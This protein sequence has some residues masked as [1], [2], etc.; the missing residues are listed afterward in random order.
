V[1]ESQ[2]EQWVPPSV[3]HNVDRSRD[4]G[5]RRIRGIR[6]PLSRLEAL[7]AANNPSTNPFVEF[8][9][10]VARRTVEWHLDNDAIESWQNEG[11]Q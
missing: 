6:L 11:G 3:L 8:A 2:I 9:R 7:R 4:L 1:S 10:A 5:D